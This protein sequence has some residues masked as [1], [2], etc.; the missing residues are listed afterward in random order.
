[1]AMVKDESACT[2]QLDNDT[3]RE[4]T[5]SRTRFPR[6]PSKR[7]ALKEVETPPNRSAVTQT[8]RV[9]ALV[10]IDTS[11]LGSCPVLR[12]AHNTCNQIG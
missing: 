7:S 1:M 9:L 3:A 11:M 5:H 6:F 8:C 2:M 12:L 10:A 4:N